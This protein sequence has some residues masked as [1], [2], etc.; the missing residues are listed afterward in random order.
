[1]NRVAIVVQRCHEDV[2]GGSETLAWHYAQLL[3]N[4]YEV[5][6]LTTTA[7]DT[8]VW[9]N[10][11]PAGTELKDSVRILRFPVTI[12]RSVYWSLLHKRLMEELGPFAPTRSQEVPQLPWSIALQEDLIR[13]Q[14]PYSAPLLRY[15]NEQWRDYRALIFITYLYPTTYFGLQQI[16]A[17]RALFAPTLHDELPA[18]LPAYKYSAQHA[19]ELVWLTSAEARV[20]QKLWGDLP[21]RVVSMAI[22]T[23]LREPRWMPAPYILY[24]GRVDPNKGCRELFDYFIRFK[25]MKPSSLRLV[26][27]GKDD[28]P[29]PVREDI[30][31]RGFV[32]PEEKFQLMAG[33]RLFVNPSPNESFSIVTLEAMAQRVPALVNSVSSVL[34]DHVKESGAGRLF[35]DYQTFAHAVDELTSDEELRSRLGQLGRDYVLSR[36]QPE[37]VRRSLISAIDR[38]A[39]GR[40]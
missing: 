20:G 28:I 7:I 25:Q 19:R 16:P 10:T 2:V 23:Q 35:S 26:I 15:I 33:A 24:S 34:A 38:A 39:D 5:D 17:G 13:H 22:D 37:I 14:G 27:T 3:S 30:E 32:T 40:G 36:Y 12:G 1:M 21:G 8:S 31:F 29:V 11:L 9:A 4:A 6:V 18:Y